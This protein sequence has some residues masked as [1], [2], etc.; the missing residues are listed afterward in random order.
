MAIDMIEAKAAEIIRQRGAGGSGPL[1]GGSGGR[2]RF[3]DD[4]LVD[5]NNFTPSR[6]RILTAFLILVVVMTFGGLLAAYIVLATNRAIEWQPFSLPIPIFL[7]TVIIL[8]SSVTYHLASVRISVDDRRSAQNWFI[9]TTILAGIFIASQLVAW[10]E[11]NRMGLYVEGNPYAGF[12]YILTGVHAIHV[13]G[14][15][16]ALGS[17]VNNLWKS[18]PSDLEK[19]RSDTM[20]QV[21]GWYWHTMGA[22]WLVIFVLLGF[23]K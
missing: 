18:D 5:P 15:V 19:L 17:L 6:P 1:T 23:W 7:S 20:A 3:S 13:I 12:F 2:R 10:F 14:G 11:L 4:E 8:A 21:V 16:I 22:L 9:A